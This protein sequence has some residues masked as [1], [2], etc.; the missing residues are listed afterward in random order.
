[1][2]NLQLAGLEGTDD[3]DDGL[4]PIR[5]VATVT[6]VNPVTLRAWERRYGLVCPRRTGP[7]SIYMASASDRGRPWHLSIWPR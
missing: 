4:F 7:G 1:M 3:G 5:T 2:R 6:R